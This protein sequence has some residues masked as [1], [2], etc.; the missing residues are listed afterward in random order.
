MSANDYA[1]PNGDPRQRLIEAVDH[2][3]HVLPGQAPILNFVHHNTLHGYQHL[4][5]TE[6]L[7][8]SKK[9]TGIHAYLP[10]EEFRKLHAQG[11]IDDADLD[12]SLNHKH[13]MHADEVLIRVGERAISRREV[14]RIGLIHGVEAILPSELNW[15]IEELQALERFQPDV[16]SS[17]R[18]RFMA[19][20]QTE[21]ESSAIY[22]LWNACLHRFDL[23]PFRLRPEELLELD[24]QEAKNTLAEFHAGSA[25]EGHSDPVAHGKM[26]DEARQTLD[27]LF[28]EVGEGLSLRG[29]LLAL[30]GQDLLDEV[31][32]LLI[33]FCAS[34]LD[35]GIAAWRAPDRAEGLYAAWKHCAGHDFGLALHD[36]PGWR[37]TWAALPEHAVDA[38]IEGLERLGIPEH[39]REGY[40]QRLA[41]EMPGW[42]GLLNWRHHRPDYPANQTAPVA[43]MDYL[44]VRL[45]L[46]GL[47]LGRICRS[48]WGLP[49]RLDALQA[50]FTRNLSE[51]TARHALFADSSLPE[52]LA[53]SA[54]KLLVQGWRE[55]DHRENWRALADMI[56]RWWHSPVAEK[57]DRPT[58]FHAAWRVFR[59]AQHLGLAAPELALLTR[60]DTDRLLGALDELTPAE[61]GY[62]W[63]WAYEHHYRE[64]LFTALAQNHGRGRWTQRNSCPE[65]Q[66]V[67]CMDD[68]EESMR[69]HLEELNPAIETLGA[70]GFFGVPMNWRGLDDREVTPL[71]PVVVTPAH[72]V[73]EEPRPGQESF[74][75]QHDRRRGLK[76]WLVRILNQEIRRNLISSKLLIDVLAPVTLPVLAGKV[77]FPRQ[78]A[79]LNRAFAA[80]IDPA[81]PT[82]L[83]FKAPADSPTATP[84]RPRLG[85][86]D[87]EQADRVAGFLR[88]IGLTYGFAPLVVIAGHGSISQNNPHLA[89]YDCGACSGRHGGPNARAFAAMANRPEVRALLKER[90]IVIPADTWFLGS[91]HNTANEDFIW[92]D[93]EDMPATFQPALATLR[94]NLDHALHLSAHER[95][96]RLASAP[97]KPSLRQAM[98]HV[99]GRTVDFSQARPELGHATNAA[100]LIGRRSVTRG[101]FF[102]RRVFL[103]SYDPTQDLD[104]KILEG[105]LLAAGPVG[106]GI[107]LE[108]YFSTVNNDRFGCGSKVPHNVTGLFAVMEGASSDLRTGL[109]RQMVEIHEAMRLQVVVEATEEVLAA[110]YQRQPPL[111]ELIGNGWLLLSAI[112]PETGAISVFEPAKGFVPWQDQQAPLPRVA[113][114]T[115]WYA[116]YSEPRPPALIST[117]EEAAHVA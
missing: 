44:A 68:R 51:F 19:A 60:D 103:I 55:P 17:T 96:R 105:I 78:Q 33:R 65:A 57:P 5:F 47:W 36:L 76:R 92:F 29:L 101:A 110:I 11:R 56:W 30:T 86:T 10:D 53:A 112:H 69:R 27:A 25:D 107:N 1:R 67:F 77:F 82:R 99:V 52:Y 88:V 75:A 24:V 70:A 89:A 79:L 39:R 113:R 114:S 94:A 61:R 80:T 41:L 109:P 20:A 37:E 15:K 66:V 22:A 34:H 14:W 35:E 18:A 40:L 54:R 108:Y 23:D 6:A 7:A 111:R 63:L 28:A 93:E 31:R 46:D 13:D 115:D 49:G 48:T 16:P 64:D 116:G 90:G 102:D 59:L 87:T 4:S 100:A 50:Y 3:D 38:V 85:F 84:Q 2:L 45:F 9:L 8:A 62:L 12:A 98:N 97:R 81:V 21:S 58:V 26:R 91:E 72:E 32:P 83:H 104:G 74:R 95:C 106:A 42:S 71:C 43:L 117:P 73:R